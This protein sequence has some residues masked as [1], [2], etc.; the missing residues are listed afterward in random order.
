[1]GRSIS[2][3]T[4][5]TNKYPC[6]LVEELMEIMQVHSFDSEQADFDDSSSDESLM[7]ISHCALAGATS[8]KSIKLQGVV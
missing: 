8:K 7:H 6:H 4:N 1:V 2:L 5:A 3:A